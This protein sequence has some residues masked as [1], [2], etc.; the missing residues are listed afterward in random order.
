VD[1]PWQELVYESGE[2]VLTKDREAIRRFNS[3]KAN[4]EHRVHLESLPE[5]FIGSPAT[6]KV[7]FL[8]LNPGHSD[9]D[10]QEHRD[11]EFQNALLKNLKHEDQ[12][13]PFYPLNPKF[14]DT[15][16]GLWW[17]TRLKH[18]KRACRLD[19]RE[20][21][22]RV[23]VIEWFPYHSVRS[24]L[25]NEIVC[26]SQKYGIRLA[27]ELSCKDGVKIVGMKAEERWTRLVGIKNVPFLR[28]KQNSTVTN[29]NMEP[30]AFEEIVRVLAT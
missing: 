30:G 24:G 3:K 6:A 13:Y 11:H 1:N 7:V 10:I 15:G 19:D 28:S 25:P 9:K 5:P 2:W 21:S 20:F 23:M 27:Q 4:P 8:G 29:R 12:E 18:L 16:A 14:K 26:A 17:T 22:K